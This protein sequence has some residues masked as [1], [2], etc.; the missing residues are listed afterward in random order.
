[1][2]EGRVVGIGQD[3]VVTHR[4]QASVRS[5]I[6]VEFSA[7]RVSRLHDR[8]FFLRPDGG[9]ECRRKDLGGSSESP[10]DDRVA[11]LEDDQATGGGEIYFQRQ[12]GILSGGQHSKGR[13]GGDAVVCLAGNPRSVESARARMP[14][15]VSTSL[16]ITKYDRWSATGKTRLPAARAAKLTRDSPSR[17]GFRAARWSKLEA[18][19]SVDGTAMY[20]DGRWQ[21][22]GPAVHGAGVA[23]AEDSGIRNTLRRL[24]RWRSGRKRRVAEPAEPEEAEELPMLGRVSRI[25]SPSQV[26]ESDLTRTGAEGASLGRN[27]GFPYRTA[28]SLATTRGGGSPTGPCQNRRTVTAPRVVPEPEPKFD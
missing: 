5:S 6:G 22:R 24:P 14:L 11:V 19:K 17:A 16:K 4:K 20:R 26:G 21:D 2:A 25:T 3:P 10:R 28:A 18:P 23:R 9:N 1:V 8:R 13:G 15:Y 27:R 12:A 7:S